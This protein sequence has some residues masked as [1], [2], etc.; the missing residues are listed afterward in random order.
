MRDMHSNH[1][2]QLIVICKYVGSEPPYRNGG[3]TA[4]HTPVLRE[5]SPPKQDVTERLMTLARPRAN[6]LY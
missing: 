2:R 3:I 5:L 4:R 1:A 6:T